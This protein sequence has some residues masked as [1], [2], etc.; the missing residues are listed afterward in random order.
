MSNSFKNLVHPVGDE[1]EYIRSYWDDRAKSFSDLRRLELKS[2]K[3]H[4]W[5]EELLCHVEPLSQDLQRP[6]RILDIGCGAGFFSI[7]LAQAGHELEGIDMSPNMVQEAEAL[8]R[9]VLGQ[10]SDKGPQAEVKP[11]FSCMDCESMA[12]QDGTFDVLVARNVMWNLPHPDVAYK[13]WLR[14]LR[15]GGIILNFDAEHAKVHH[16]LNEH[17]QYADKTVSNDLLTRCHAM[18]HMLAISGLDR[19]EW[20]QA[21]LADYAVQ[22]IEIDTSVAERMYP[23]EDELYIPAPMFLVKVIK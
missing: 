21:L 6:L 5:F 9:E 2:E 4:L 19:P 13:E 3:T 20:D 12:F 16:K 10:D 23:K 17:Q 11:T 8:A 7:L 15:P 18:Y 14:V 1:K 22:N